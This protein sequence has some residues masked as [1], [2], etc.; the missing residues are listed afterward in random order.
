MIDK[1]IEAAI[2][3]VFGVWLINLLCEWLLDISP[4]DIFVRWMKHLDK[5]LDDDE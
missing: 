2:S 3:I 1:I 4:V 5:E